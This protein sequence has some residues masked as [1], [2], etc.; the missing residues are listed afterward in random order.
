[1]FGTVVQ[2]PYEFGY[3][4]V[5][6]LASLAKGDKSGLPKGGLEIIPT[7]AVTPKT[8]DAYV[9]EQNKLLGKS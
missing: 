8:V 3:A 6:L 5:K 9:A 4:S 2:Q 1:V 7:E